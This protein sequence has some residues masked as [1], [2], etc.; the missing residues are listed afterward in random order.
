MTPYAEKKPVRRHPA[1][2]RKEN[3]YLQ[4]IK[5]SISHKKTKRMKAM[6]KILY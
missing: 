5:G 3:D 1:K 2:D 4:T 6:D